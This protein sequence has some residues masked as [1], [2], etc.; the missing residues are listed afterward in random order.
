MGSKG[1]P[2]PLWE[3]MQGKDAQCS[4]EKHHVCDGLQHS[5]VVVFCPHAACEATGGA[6]LLWHSARITEFESAGL[7]CCQGGGP[8]RGLLKHDYVS[9]V[10]LGWLQQSMIQEQRVCTATW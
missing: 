9:S 4:D 3:D 5:W 1:H 7:V 2:P 8:Q 10:E 6:Q